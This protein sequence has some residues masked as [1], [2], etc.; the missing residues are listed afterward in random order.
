MSPLFPTEFCVALAPGR[1]EITRRAYGLKRRIESWRRADL[2]PAGGETSGWRFAID[3]LAE[4]LAG[5]SSI[6]GRVQVVLSS[7]WVRFQVVPWNAGITTPAEF[8]EYARACFAQ[9]HGEVTDG[10]E[11]RVDP[12]AA[13]Q[14]RMAC[15]IDRELLANLAELIEGR[16]RRLIGVQP[17][18]MH[19]FN[20]I[21]SLVG[22][23]RFLFVL[24][25]P[26][27]ATLAA[28]DRGAWCSVSNSPLAEGDDALAALIGRELQLIGD[29]AP[30]EV[31][32]HAPRV[33]SES[34]ARVEAAGWQLIPAGGGADYAMAWGTRPR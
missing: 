3:A 2:A 32:V 16:G 26:G 12:A 31:L 29:G 9:V 21:A 23:K 10:W 30:T 34:L 7:H 20:P 11:T 15:A 28:A 6:R 25:E 14:G 24:V 4:L 33:A 13:G 1:I 27:R 17:Y 19:A 22:R 5:E 8:A 18:L